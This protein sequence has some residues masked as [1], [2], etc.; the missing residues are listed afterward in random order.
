[1]ELCNDDF[2]L[3]RARVGPLAATLENVYGL[4]D[5]WDEV[6]CLAFMPLA[7]ELF[8]V[9]VS[10]MPFTCHVYLYVYVCVCTVSS[11]KIRDTGST[12]C[13]KDDLSWSNQGLRK[14]QKGWLD[15]QVLCVLP[16]DVSIKTWR[17]SDATTC[18][19]SFL[20]KDS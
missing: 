13:H 8:Y 11:F 17:A 2:V 9:F 18:L 10:F 4:I 20:E 16:P 5:A 15:K 7:V 12:T 3:F 1:M 19:H 14:N 6:S